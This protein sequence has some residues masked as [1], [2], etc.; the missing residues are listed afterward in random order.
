MILWA[1]FTTLFKMFDWFLIVVYSIP[2]P[3]WALTVVMSVNV[4]KHACVD[5]S[6][7]FVCSDNSGVIAQL[8]IFKTFN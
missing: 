5:M 6:V 2:N 7:H 8:L 1:V 3:T 4:G